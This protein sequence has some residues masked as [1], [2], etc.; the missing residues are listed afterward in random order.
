MYDTLIK[1][2]LI[3][4]ILTILLVR[5]VSMLRKATVLHRDVTAGK[6]DK[7][8]VHITRTRPCGGRGIMARGVYDIDGEKVMCSMI[9]ACSMLELRRG[10]DKYV[11]IGKSDGSVFALDEA[12]SRDAVMT[13]WVFTV[14]AGLGVLFMAVGIVFKVLR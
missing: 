8:R 2:I 13:W 12:Q 5:N 10:D 1:T 11:I 3:E 6:T 9:C 14:L 4:T 7:V